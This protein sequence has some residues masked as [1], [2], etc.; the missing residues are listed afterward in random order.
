MK[1]VKSVIGWVTTLF[2]LIEGYKQ[3]S[4]TIIIIIIIITI[5]ICIYCICIFIVKTHYVLCLL[6]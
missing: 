6:F 3:S 5:C 1:F 2:S 4:G